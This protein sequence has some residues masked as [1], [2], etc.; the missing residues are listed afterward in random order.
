MTP[1]EL[2]LLLEDAAEAARAIRRLEARSR[3]LDDT[4]R[5]PPL[6]WS[7]EPGLAATYRALAGE[8]RRCAA[9]ASSLG[10]RADGGSGAGG[11]RDTTS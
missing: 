11:S 7:G 5:R 1:H 9:L 3:Q 4:G 8:C 10:L 6:S 2:R